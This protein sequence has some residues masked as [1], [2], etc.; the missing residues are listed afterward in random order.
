MAPALPLA[1]IE[2]EMS[3]K[4]S[5]WHLLCQMTII[6]PLWSSHLL[7]SSCWSTQRHGNQ[8]PLLTCEIIRL[9]VAHLK[10]RIGTFI[11]V[12]FHNDHCL[13]YSGIH[14]VAFSCQEI[15]II[16]HYQNATIVVVFGNWCSS[17]W[18][19]IKSCCNIHVKTSNVCFLR[20]VSLSWRWCDGYKK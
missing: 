4:T 18:I 7:L 19:R 1:S 20:L 10:L 11:S 14:G 12:A 3:N 5:M 8:G 6:T 17:A 13:V 16:V 9:F 2:G 15:V